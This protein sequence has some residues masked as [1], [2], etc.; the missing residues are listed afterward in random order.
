MTPGIFSTM[1]QCL[2]VY[3]AIIGGLYSTI[4]MDDELTFTVSAKVFI[5]CSVIYPMWMSTKTSKLLV[6]LAHF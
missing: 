4:S 1:M 2:A 3:I 6:Y 5:R